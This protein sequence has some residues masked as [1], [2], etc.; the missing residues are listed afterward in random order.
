MIDSILGPIILGIILKIYIKHPKA[1]TKT[2]QQQFKKQIKIITNI[3][4]QAELSQML[5]IQA[6]IAWVVPLA[7]KEPANLPTNNNTQRMIASI[8][9]LSNF[10]IL[11]LA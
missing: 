4:S 3:L 6:P 11:S 5:H 8:V 9:V 7:F 1:L 10:L 2:R